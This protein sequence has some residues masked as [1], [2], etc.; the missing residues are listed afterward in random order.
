MPLRGQAR[1]GKQDRPAQ[2]RE[3]VAE[4]SRLPELSAGSFPDLAHPDLALPAN[5]LRRGQLLQA[6]QHTLGNQALQRAL[7]GPPV[8]QALPPGIIARVPTTTAQGIAVQRPRTGTPG[9]P[10]ATLSDTQRQ[11]VLGHIQARSYDDAVRTMWDA[12]R[13]GLALA[14]RVDV[15]VGRPMGEWGGQSIAAAQSDA[16]VTLVYVLHRRECVGLAPVDHRQLHDASELHFLVQINP[17]TLGGDAQEAVARLQTTLMHEYVHVEQQ[18]ARG[19]EENF[20]FR[21][22]GAREF[23]TQTGATA[24]PSRELEA[25]DEIEAP[26]AEIENAER[27]GLARTYDL[28]T[29]VDLLWSKYRDYFSAANGQPDR[30][31]ATRV[32]ENIRRGRRLFAA[33]LRSPA[34]SW[35]RGTQAAI[36]R[37][38]PP[39]YNEQLLV[40]FL[41]QPAA[42]PAPAP[43]Q[44][45]TP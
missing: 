25:L 30:D 4:R 5:T 19:I 42:G 36:Y 20:G 21:L 3:R 45:T 13:G 29:A 33:Y 23:V 18:V 32:Y 37:N 8:Q 12:L 39:G 1:T 9:T 28:H 2:P 27:T 10:W 38:T 26:C 11:E 6:W 17:S 22:V 44:Q 35:M 16:G 14:G 34:A 15:E 24:A 41:N 43:A 31:V 40:P 7:L